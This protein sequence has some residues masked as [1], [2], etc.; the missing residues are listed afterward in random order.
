GH[1]GTLPLEIT[2]MAEDQEVA[3]VMSLKTI[4][5]SNSLK[6]ALSNLP[7]FLALQVV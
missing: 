7:S 1:A 4:D 5:P 3:T 2:F 6:E